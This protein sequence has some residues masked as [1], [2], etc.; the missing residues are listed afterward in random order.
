MPPWLTQEVRNGQ[1]KRNIIM[2]TQDKIC[3]Y[4][5]LLGFKYLLN[6]NVDGVLQLLSDYN[7]IFF[8]HFEE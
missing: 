8:A 6:K 3:A 1:R 4:L 7:T 5:D 2:K